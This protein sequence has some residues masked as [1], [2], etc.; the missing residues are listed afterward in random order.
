MAK[1]HYNLKPM[2]AQAAISEL[3]DY[4]LGKDWVCVDPLCASQVNAII[5]DDIKAAYP[6]ADGGFL[7]WLRW[8][9]E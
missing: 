3:C 1:I 2:D 4:L 9:F 6:S 7:A 5:V 8:R